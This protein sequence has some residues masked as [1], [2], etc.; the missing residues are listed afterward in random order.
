MHLFKVFAT[1]ILGASVVAPTVAAPVVRES[2]SRELGAQFDEIQRARSFPPA[3]S[4]NKPF[5]TTKDG[6]TVAKEI[7]L[8]RTFQNSPAQ[9]TKQ[10][11]TKTN[12]EASTANKPAAKGRRNVVLA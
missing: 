6:S 12:D 8:K 10:S 2:D 3:S 7:E 1:L 11:A 5:G 9:L 4:S